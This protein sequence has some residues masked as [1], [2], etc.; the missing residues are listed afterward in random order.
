[1]RTSLAECRGELSECGADSNAMYVLA[2]DAMLPFEARE[3]QRKGLGRVGWVFNHSTDYSTDLDHVDQHR[4]QR[5]GCDL[6]YDGDLRLEIAHFGGV[7]R[8]GWVRVG[9]GS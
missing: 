5:R 1:M 8:C 6:F 2:V 4:H 9:N 3:S 7:V